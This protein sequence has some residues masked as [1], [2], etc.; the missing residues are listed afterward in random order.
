MALDMVLRPQMV[1]AQQGQGRRFASFGP[2]R[3]PVNRTLAAFLT[4]QAGKNTMEAEIDEGSN[5]E[6]T[7]KYLLNTF[8]A[9]AI[10]AAS[11]LVNSSASHFASPTRAG[12]FCAGPPWLVSS[13]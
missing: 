1:R 10:G 13:N 9:S 8:T 6:D 4:T 7:K 12:A 11:G 3:S 2:R 5:D